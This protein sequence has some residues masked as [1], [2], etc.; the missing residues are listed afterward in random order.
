MLITNRLQGLNQLQ[1]YLLGSGELDEKL[2]KITEGV[3]EIF[4]A[5][6]CRIWIKGPG[7]LCEKGCI[8]A[9]AKDP[10][11]VCRLREYCLHLVASSGRYT[12]IDGPHSRMPFGL[13]KVGRIAVGQISKFL[14]NNVVNDPQIMDHKWAKGLGLVSF[15]GYR[16]QD[17]TGG[18]IG[19]LALFSKQ[20][21]TTEEDAMLEGLAGITAHVIQTVKAEGALKVERDKLINILESMGDGVYIGSQTYDIEYIN[22]V[23]EREFGPINGRKCYEYFH[24]RDEVCPWCKGKEAFAGKTVRREWYSAKNNKTYDLL[25]TPLQNRDGTISKLEIFHDITERKYAEDALE[26]RTDQLTAVTGAICSFLESGDWHKTSSM[27][28]SSALAQTDSEYG[29]IGVVVDLKNGPALRIFAIEGIDWDKNINLEIYE[30]AIRSF[31]E[32]GYLDF[33]N[34][35][36]LFGRVITSS[37]AVISNDLGKD[38]RSGGRL[39]PGHPHLLSFLGV[40]IFKGQ[41]V[42]G[43]IGVANRQGGYTGEEQSRIEVLCQATSILYDSY[44]RHQKEVAYEEERK[45]QEEAIHHLAYYDMLTNLPNRL[46]LHDDIDR[47]IS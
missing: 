13:Y 30:N 42:V 29:F 35:D 47:A 44:L 2:T 41:D 1:Q 20:S 39:P 36:N 4:N 34:L 46:S 9:T 27:I 24:D 17:T 22:P 45:R 12:H 14:T 32:T 33:A 25:E 43:I 8:H 37:S 21:I 3:T 10:E 40:P 31:Q 28:L 38:P 26:A 16:L 18:P 23:I 5:D 11:K 19:V 6:F 15:A 7:D